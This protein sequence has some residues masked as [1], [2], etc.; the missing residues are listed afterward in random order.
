MSLKKPLSA[1]LIS[2]VFLLTM[3]DDSPSS[4]SVSQDDLVGLWRAV[5]Y[6]ESWDFPADNYR[7]TETEAIT[8]SSEFILFDSKNIT[9]LYHYSYD[10]C[11]EIMSVPYSLSGNR[12]IGEDFSGSYDGCTLSTTLQVNGNTLTVLYTYTDEDG[13]GKMKITYK[14]FAG[15][16][17][18][19]SWPEKECLSKKADRKIFRKYSRPQ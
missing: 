13:Y 3:C 10:D 17:P 8:D 5:E 11:V 14:R 2:S 1:A 9:F 16:V 4:A 12:L 18:P 15:T 19:A 6:E 7:G